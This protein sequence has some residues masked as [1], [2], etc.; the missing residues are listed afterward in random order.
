MS[1]RIAAY[2]ERMSGD[3]AQLFH[4]QYGIA[5]EAFLDRFTRFY[6]HPYQREQCR[7][8]VTLSG[9]TVVGFTGFCAWP[10]RLGARQ[11]RSFQYCDAIV[12]P[13]WRGRGA[14][15]RMLDALDETQEVDFAVGFPVEASRSSFVSNGRRN[16]L[17]LHWYVKLLE[18]FA[19]LGRRE[20]V[21]EAAA[22]HEESDSHLRLTDDAAFIDWRRG[23]S[24][25]QRYFVRGPFELKSIRRKRLLR[26][27]I[28]GDV[29]GDDADFGAL[30]AHVHGATYLSIALSPLDPL[31][32][33]VRAAGFRKIDRRITFV[34][35]P[36][37]NEDLVNDPARWRLFRADIDTW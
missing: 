11:F 17:D 5:R 26:E 25:R 28:I 7:R 21:D 8:V 10:Y 33:R 34:V 13:D 9:D 4:R 24:H 27:M 3:V 29:R 12:D 20:T 37:S 22:S 18:P 35:K 30:A 32:T 36:F 15:R 31:V 14:F 6:E 19:F 1:I 16:L 23:Y 2:E